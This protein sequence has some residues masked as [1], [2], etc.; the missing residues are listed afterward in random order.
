LTL[1]SAAVMLPHVRKHG[2]CTPKHG[3]Q[4]FYSPL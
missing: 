4:L 1:W 3:D 2:L